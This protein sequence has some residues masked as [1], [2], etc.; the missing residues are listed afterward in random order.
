MTGQL[1]E[2][3]QKALKTEPKWRRKQLQLCLTVTILHRVD[4]HWPQGDRTISVVLKVNRR[5][6]FYSCNKMPTVGFVVT[7]VK[8]NSR[9][10]CYS[11]KTYSYCCFF[12]AETIVFTISVY[13]CK[14]IFLLLIFYSCT[15]I[16]LL[17]MFY[18]CTN[19]SYC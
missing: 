19:Y 1:R 4:P 3:A 12:T 17:L 13:S 11:C 8:I 9:N 10:I 14:T 6:I 15:N 18:S 5:N 7:V 16:F 2:R